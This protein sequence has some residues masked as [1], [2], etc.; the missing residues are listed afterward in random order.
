MKP[1][2][3]ALLADPPAPGVII[4]RQDKILHV[5]F[6]A[7]VG[8]KLFSRCLAGMAAALP[9]ALVVACVSLVLLLLANGPV[10]WIALAGLILSGLGASLTLS[11]F[12]I[13]VVPGQTRAGFVLS[14]QTLILHDGGTTT[15]VPWSDIKAVGVAYMKRPAR[16][17]HARADWPYVK[18][19]GDGLAITTSHPTFKAFA[20]W[21]DDISR[22]SGQLIS[23]WAD[24]PLIDDPE[25]HPTAGS[26][27]GRAGDLPT[28]RHRQEA[29]L[30][31]AV[32]LV[33]AGLIGGLAAPAAWRSLTVRHWT[34]VSG[35]V[36]GVFPESRA[37]KNAG[38]SRLEVLYLYT[39]NGHEHQSKRFR[40]G[41]EADYSLDHAAKAA[42]ASVDTV[43]VW[44]HPRHPER[45]VLS[46]APSFAAFGALSVAL[47]LGAL[48][49]RS[50]YHAWRKL[51]PTGAI[52]YD[53]THEKNGLF[54][55]EPT[56]RLAK[57]VRR[58]ARSGRS[59]DT[60]GIG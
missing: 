3:T 46:P 45:A 29:A 40:L 13:L 14:D 50:L 34:Q 54:D 23:A 53:V 42:L 25:H 35:N 6:K 18:G 11:L 27:R 59:T 36:I 17:L 60:R 22:W 47:V 56:P 19:R 58:K 20:S 55:G 7:G 8:Q 24:L 51:K 38:K 30:I 5:R 48:S 49:L 41:Y 57:W 4:D 33:V 21:H 10:W 16:Q 28:S 44:H 52:A 15:E 39:V 2:V 32:L 12:I 1:D 31:G 9:V 43:T 37:L 26:R